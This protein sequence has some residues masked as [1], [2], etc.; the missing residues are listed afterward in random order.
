M[1][2][3]TLSELKDC[4]SAFANDVRQ[5]AVLTGAGMS[6]ESGVPTFRG[7]D[8]LWRGMAP[9]ELF[10]PQALQDD[11]ALIWQM[12]DEL[13]CRI[14]AAP[15]N[16]GHLALAALASRRR[17]SLATQNI[18]GLHQR[19]GSTALQELHGTLWRLRCTACGSATDDLRAPLPALPP[20]CARCAE[21]LRP[22][23]VLFS[24]SLPA[25]ASRAAVEAAQSCA[26][27]LVIGTSGV[28]YP[29]AGLPTLARA[30]GAT[31]LEINPHAT[32][33]TP[34]MDYSLRATAAQA[35]PVLVRCLVSR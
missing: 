7:R 4:L 19:A 31:V 15:P 27:M 3:I 11:P 1:P 33:L 32:A 26:L 24:E 13:R 5:I 34:E 28:V 16:A 6:A 2:I 8:G 17:V 12:Y 14:A 29:A 22:D 30:H 20:R 9:E 10:S 18:D 35:L 25:E 23:I 21:I